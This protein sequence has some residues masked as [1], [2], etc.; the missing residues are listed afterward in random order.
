MN[1]LGRDIS[2]LTTGGILDSYSDEKS[3]PRTHS[4][5]SRH[6]SKSQQSQSSDTMNSRE[7]L[8]LSDPAS[9]ARVYPPTSNLTRTSNLS[10]NSNPNSSNH[11]NVAVAAGA[12]AGT[13]GS[14]VPAQRMLELNDRILEL[15]LKLK[16]AN[17]LADVERR[18]KQRLLEHNNE[19]GNELNEVRKALKDMQLLFFK[20]VQHATEQM[21]RTQEQRSSQLHDVLNENKELDQRVRELTIRLRTAEF[22]VSQMPLQ[23]QQAIDERYNR[24]KQALDIAEGSLDS[25][26]R[27]VSNL[28]EENRNLQSIIA[29]LR[30]NRLRADEMD[31]SVQ[32]QLL[33]NQQKAAMA[34]SLRD[35]LQ[36]AQDMVNRQRDEMKYLKQEKSDSLAVVAKRDAMILELRESLLREKEAKLEAQ[37]EKRIIETE[38]QLVLKTATS[39]GDPTQSPQPLSPRFGFTNDGEKDRLREENQRLR[40]E[41]SALEAVITKKDETIEQI[42]LEL[43]EE[44]QNVLRVKNEK[45]ILEIENEK[46]RQR[47]DSDVPPGGSPLAGDKMEQLLAKM[48]MMESIISSPMYA[49]QQQQQQPGFQPVTPMGFRG[50]NPNGFNNQSTPMQP[51]RPNDWNT[52]SNG[53][54]PNRQNRPV[55]YN[56]NNNNNSGS[57]SFSPPNRLEG[58]GPYPLNRQASQSMPNQGPPPNL[59]PQLQVP[60][61][62]QQSQQQQQQPQQQRDQP[63]YGAVTNRPAFGRTNSNLAAGDSAFEPSQAVPQ[64]VSPRGGRNNSD[65]S[66]SGSVHHHHSN[67]PASHSRKQDRDHKETDERHHHGEKPHDK[68]N[69]N[70]R[71]DRHDKEPHGQGRQSRK[72][73]DNHH[74]RHGSHDDHDHHDHYD[75]DTDS[76]HEYRNSNRSK[77]V[78]G[79]KRGKPKISIAVDTTTNTTESTDD[80][81]MS[82]PRNS[83]AASSSGGKLTMNKSKSGKQKF[84]Q[85][86]FIHE[87]AD[88]TP[89]AI[90]ASVAGHDHSALVEYLERATHAVTLATA[91]KEAVRK[92]VVEWTEHYKQ[93]HDG[94]GPKADDRPADLK[95][96]YRQVL[97]H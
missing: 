41:K 92:E 75:E 43:F 91:A 28:K 46:L 52:N 25:S 17:G 95:A 4:N 30:K 93:E 89:D 19:L 57:P 40:H 33:A 58:P 55:Q 42:R 47:R 66:E 85:S 67:K 56:G 54:S 77:E 97:S 49:M 8:H 86:S 84:G 5:R 94:A 45:R 20:N 62:Q 59:Q 26:R 65:S 64:P 37:S 35:Q 24:I 18:E 51:A 11:N 78:A 87:L 22:Q 3:H 39:S 76:K 29:D 63:A 53:P 27:E 12:G 82:S 38:L 48:S 74:D 2:P 73:Q 50:A 1:Y 10:S 80:L 68:E 13:S 70:D 36:T 6:N 71:H 15:K 21:T 72:H 79:E 81:M 44:K 88:I 34:D 83:S 60:Q 96:K 31:D 7:H 14:M 90:A 61:Q 9:D 32:A 16:E 69:A 23:Q